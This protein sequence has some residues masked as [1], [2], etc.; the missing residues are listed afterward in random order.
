M[1]SH[2]LDKLKHDHQFELP[3]RGA[4]RR[5]MLVVGMTLVT[6]V[7]EIS[8]GMLF[9]SMALLADGWHMGTH[10]RRPGDH[11][12]CVLSRAKIRP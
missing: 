2:N 5:V 9:G 1:H 3:D 4:E 11:P 6:M 7:A 8:A 10:A 12:A